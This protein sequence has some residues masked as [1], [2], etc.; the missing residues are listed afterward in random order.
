LTKGTLTHMWNSVRSISLVTALGA[1]TVMS[2]VLAAPNPAAARPGYASIV[3]DWETGRVIS[4]YR[5][6]KLHAPASLTK[7]MTLYLLFEAL[8]AKRIKLDQRLRVSTHAQYARPSKLGLRAGTTIT[9]REAI[10]ALVTK[11]ANDAAVVIAEALGGTEAQFAQTMTARARQIGMTHTTFR[12]ASG[13]PARGQLTTARDMAILARTIIKTFP[14]HYH[15]FSTRYFYFHGQRHGNHNRLLGHYPGVD[16]LKTGFVRASGYNLIVSARN[17]AGTRIVAVVLGG[18]SHRDR[19][20]RMTGLLDYSFGNKTR[21]ASL[22]NH[23]GHVMAGHT[24]RKAS[25]IATAR[26]YAAARHTE[27]VYRR[28]QRHSAV[29]GRWSV[30]VGAFRSYRRAR[31]ATYLAKRRASALHHAVPSVVKVS[32]SRYRYRARLQGLTRQQAYLAC[33][34]LRRKGARC[35]VRGPSSS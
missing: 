4:A 3:I 31:Q 6:D 29:R 15:Y 1:L 8:D 33:R 30:Q 25:A 7:V 11:S 13:L 32:R 23:G 24:Q 5:A 22:V 20:I 27:S 2:L 16:G 28:A 18:R 21:Y 12:N 19:D 26:S 35:A 10:L 9:V 14:H 34:S 17:R